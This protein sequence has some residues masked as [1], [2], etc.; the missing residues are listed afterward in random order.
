MWTLARVT[1]LR[2]GTVLLYTASVV[3]MVTNAKT[4]ENH[5]IK[6][7]TL[8]KEI[9]L[10]DDQRKWR[11]RIG[12]KISECTALLCNMMKA[13]YSF[14]NDNDVRVGMAK[15]TNVTRGYIQQTAY[16]KFKRHYR[17]FSCIMFFEKKAISVSSVSFSSHLSHGIT[18][19]LCICRLQLNLS[20]YALS[21]CELLRLILYKT[22]HAINY[23]YSLYAGENVRNV[24][25]QVAFL[26]PAKIQT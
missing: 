10:G 20:W 24:W 12:T 26:S 22:W 23:K 2:N 3:A 17:V 4:P 19:T 18:P 6:N 9:S 15:F 13:L 25:K 14:F 8:I 16:S 11:E 21:T 7:R 1:K 5:F